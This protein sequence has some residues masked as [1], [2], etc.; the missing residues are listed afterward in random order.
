MLVVWMVVG[1]GW[2]CMAGVWMAA[3]GGEQSLL[4]GILRV[5]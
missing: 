2:E 4:V 5:I 1:Q 3:D